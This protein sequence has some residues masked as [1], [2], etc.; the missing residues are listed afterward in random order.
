MEQQNIKPTAFNC[1]KSG[2]GFLVEV[3]KFQRIYHC[4]EKC[5]LVINTLISCPL[6]DPYPDPVKKKVHK[7]QTKE[8]MKREIHKS[9][10]IRDAK[11]FRSYNENII[12]LLKKHKK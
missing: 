3:T 2:C 5:G 8:Q 1:F 4:C 6:V 9:E 10:I 11:T 7:S 12:N